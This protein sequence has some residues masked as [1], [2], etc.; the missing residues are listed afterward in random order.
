MYSTRVVE[1]LLIDNPLLPRGSSPTIRKGVLTCFGALPSRCGNRN[2]SGSEAMDEQPTVT[3]NT[4]TKPARNRFAIRLPRLTVRSTAV[5]SKPARR[6]K[7][8]GQTVAEPC[9]DDG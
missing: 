2:I 5:R 1:K 4:A 6:P 9:S 7:Y 3:A 8:S